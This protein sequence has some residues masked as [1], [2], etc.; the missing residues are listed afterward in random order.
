MSLIVCFHAIEYLPPNMTCFK[1][2]SY[3]SDQKITIKSSLKDPETVFL[4]RA[5]KAVNYHDGIPWIFFSNCPWIWF[6]P[7]AR[8]M[9]IHL[10]FV[11]K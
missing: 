9:A 1:F 8:K 6:Q 2:I 4:P 11:V 7:F 3:I 5:L 10:D